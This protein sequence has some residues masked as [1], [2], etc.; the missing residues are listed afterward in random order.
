VNHSS[1]R[2]RDLI[3]HRSL[4]WD[5]HRRLPARLL[6]DGTIIIAG[7]VPMQRTPRTPGRA[8]GNGRHRR[9]EMSLVATLESVLA[10][11]K[12]MGVGEIVEAVQRKGYQSNSANFRGI[13]NQTLIK[14]KQF[15]SAGRGVSAEEVEAAGCGATIFGQ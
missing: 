11:G 8:N 14:E 15:S 5:Q 7:P 3:F 1:A 9:N 13:V 4:L 12:P 10:P 2:G 6:A